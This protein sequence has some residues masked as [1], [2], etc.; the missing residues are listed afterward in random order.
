MSEQNPGNETAE[1]RAKLAQHHTA[2]NAPV[3]ATRQGGSAGHKNQF[4]HTRMVGQD[5]LVRSHVGV[6]SHDNPGGYSPGKKGG[7][8]VMP[9]VRRANLSRQHP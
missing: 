2:A 8:E 3:S 7:G 1:G 5:P 6:R 9:K 4:G